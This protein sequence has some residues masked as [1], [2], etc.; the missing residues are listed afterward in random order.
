MTTTFH[1]KR[2]L[3]IFKCLKGETTEE[4]ST[5]TVMKGIFKK[6]KPHFLKSM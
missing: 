3:I 5:H 2:N 6:P 1:A 4:S